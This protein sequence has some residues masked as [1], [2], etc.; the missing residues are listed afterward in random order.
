[1]DKDMPPDCDVEGEH[2]KQEPVEERI[3]Q[4]LRTARI[5]I[6]E[7]RLSEHLLKEGYEE[8]T[9]QLAMTGLMLRNEVR[10]VAYRGYMIGGRPE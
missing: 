5:P 3:L 9:V 10:W 2:L 1:M 4:F 8:E 6:S 7:N